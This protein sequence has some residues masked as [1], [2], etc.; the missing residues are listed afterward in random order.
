MEWSR[1]C[2]SI[3]KCRKV[4]SLREPEYKGEREQVGK[5]S[6]EVERGV[7]EGIVGVIAAVQRVAFFS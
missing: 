5:R 1:N 2:T 7:K 4:W 6:S 3:R